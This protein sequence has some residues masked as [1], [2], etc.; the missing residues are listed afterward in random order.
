MYTDLR[1]Q[2]CG[3][4]A[5][6]NDAGIFN[7]RETIMS[8]DATIDIGG[9]KLLNFCTPD[10]LALNHICSNNAITACD[11][12]ELEKQIAQLLNADSCILYNSQADANYALTNHLL[13]R[14]DAVIYC[15][16]SQFAMSG[17][18]TF[19]RPT[20]YKF[21][22]F[23]TTDIEKQLKIAQA[24]QNRLIIV[25]AVDMASGNIAPLNHIFALANRYKAIVAIDQTLSAGLIGHGGHG[26]FTIFDTI[27]NPEMQTGSL[28]HFGLSRGAYIAGRREIIDF[29]RQ[30][31]I[32]LSF[33]A[34]LTAH[35]IAVARNAIGTATAM[36]TERQYILQITNYF[37]K[38]LYCLGLEIPPTQTS[39]LAIMVGDSRKAS[40]ISS[41]LAQKGVL[42]QAA[43][44]PLTSKD[45][46]RL[47]ISLSANHTKDDI[48]QAT[49]IFES[50]LPMFTCGQQ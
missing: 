41:T 43:T 14:N 18:P 30:Q 32:P 2:L 35:D 10:P 50:L 37:I 40:L 9:H 15:A 39:R 16:L 13:N 19:C 20:K 4:L 34:P 25:D 11:T 21:H 17:G 28:R 3:Y 26:I 29:L 22:S 36:D 38:K 47:I 46:A 49:K 23:D 45:E 42:V 5:A 12:T 27:D 8:A 31:P 7:S 24:Q 33:D 1:E 44:S 6:I 48:E